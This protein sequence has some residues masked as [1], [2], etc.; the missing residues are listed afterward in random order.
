MESILLILTDICTLIGFLF[1]TRNFLEYFIIRFNLYKVA[2]EFLFS[3][4][5]VLKLFFGLKGNVIEGTA[6]FL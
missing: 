1:H 5:Q 3:E 2:L 4:S 6:L